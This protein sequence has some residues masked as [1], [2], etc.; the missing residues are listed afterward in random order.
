MKNK[1]TNSNS[2]ILIS[3]ILACIALFIG[4]PDTS[5]RDPNGET[6]TSGAV[7]LYCDDEIAMM[8]APCIDS[9]KTKFPDAKVEVQ[10]MTAR[11]VMGQLLGGKARCIVLGRT[12]LSDERKLMKEHN[13][14]EHKQ[15]HIATDA[16]VFYVKKDFPADT[17]SASALQ[18]YFDK[19]EDK[20]F[21]AEKGKSIKAEFAC[22][23]PSTS[24]YAHLLKYC[25]TQ[26]KIHPSLK[27]R[28][29]STID[30]VKA[31]VLN[32]EHV[33]GIGLLSAVA[34]DTTRFKMLRIGYDDSTGTHRLLKVH[35]STVYRE[36]YPYPVQII[37]Y[38]F[39][40]VRKLPYGLMSYLSTD[41]QAQRVFLDAG[42]VPAYAKIRLIEEE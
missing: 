4:C 34:Q 30:S 8:I 39:E 12:Y 27:L 37:G 36:R 13:V 28:Y 10:K 18:A 14:A 1:K 17:I 31:Y 21:S 5:Q 11:S 3:S 42:I 33:I 25:T 23:Y 2:I 15:F 9:M 26:E 16:L 38:L 6:F 40:D 41:A 19:G 35:Q 29:L 24:S 32:K 22:L 20:L 7:T